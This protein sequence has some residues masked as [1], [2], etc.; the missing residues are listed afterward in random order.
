MG[1]RWV[2]HKIVLEDHKRGRRTEL[3]VNEIAIDPDLNDNMFSVTR[4]GAGN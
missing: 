1:E 3:V 2:P 4:F